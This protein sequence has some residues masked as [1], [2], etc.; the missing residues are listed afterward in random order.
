MGWRPEA[1]IPPVRT[2]PR[3]GALPLVLP[4]PVRLLPCQGARDEH[5]GKGLE[6]GI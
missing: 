2:E 5:T 1:G 4:M 6:D 3:W